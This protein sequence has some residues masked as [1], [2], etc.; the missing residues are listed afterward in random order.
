[1]HTVCESNPTAMYFKLLHHLERWTPTVSPRQDKVRLFLP[2]DTEYSATHE[3][4]ASPERFLG[5]SPTMK[6]LLTVEVIKFLSIEQQEH[7][8]RASWTSDRG[9]NLNLPRV[10]MSQEE[11]TS[12]QLSGRRSHQA[13]R[14]HTARQDSFDG[15]SF[16]HRWIL[17]LSLT[18]ITI[19]P[20]T[21]SSG[22]D[23]SEVSESGSSSF[24]FHWLSC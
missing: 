11:A 5:D 13:R 18:F 6:I 4:Q 8:F 7:P 16:P 10:L 2:L 20:S 23:T 1:M 3:R 14:L 9:C 24:V 17:Q 19:S 12:C 22:A 15:S 21:S